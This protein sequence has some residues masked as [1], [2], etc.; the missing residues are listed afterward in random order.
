MW[1]SWTRVT[2]FPPRSRG[3]SRH[4]ARRH[5]AVRRHGC[6]AASVRSVGASGSEPALTLAAQRRPRSSLRGLRR[7]F[8]GGAARGAV[9]REV[10]HRPARR[11]ERRLI[12]EVRSTA[13]GGALLLAATLGLLGCVGLWLTG[14][15]GI[16]SS[17]LW[18][19]T[20][21]DSTSRA[22]RACCSGRRGTSG[23]RLSRTLRL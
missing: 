13:T 21:R 7:R 17:A 8:A 9:W 6:H 5:L 4:R 18:A 3:S 10:P 12:G 14:A 19:E 20:T 15:F 1:S 2:R 11:L 16:E 22:A 23:P